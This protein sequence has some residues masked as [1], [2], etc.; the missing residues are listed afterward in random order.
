LNP[1]DA[2]KDISEL[3]G[4]VSLIIKNVPFAQDENVIHQRSKGLFVPAS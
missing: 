4:V 3:V 1:K 2:S